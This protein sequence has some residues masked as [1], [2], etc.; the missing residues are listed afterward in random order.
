MF[1]S[2]KIWGK[3]EGKKGKKIERKSRRKWKMK[4]EK[5]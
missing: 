3:C 1:G 2:D 4:N 5:K